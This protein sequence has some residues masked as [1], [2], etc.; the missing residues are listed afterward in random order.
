MSWNNVIVAWKRLVLTKLRCCET[1][2]SADVYKWGYRCRLERI[3][4][5]AMHIHMIDSFQTPM[6]NNLCTLSEANQGSA[7][8]MVL[9]LPE[10]GGTSVLKL[11]RAQMGT[12]LWLFLNTFSPS[13][14]LIDVL[15][16]QP[17]RPPVVYK[18]LLPSYV[19]AQAL[20]HWEGEQ[21]EMIFQPS[22][23]VIMNL[24]AV[25]WVVML[26]YCYVFIHRYIFK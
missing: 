11:Q 8:Y 6:F 3:S 19:T 4:Y 10:M 13:R 18:W 23:D 12:S 5:S 9:Y 17:G 25:S 21:S 26:I 1:V 20:W 2:L 14:V 15:Q 7:R 24:L 22:A 16:G